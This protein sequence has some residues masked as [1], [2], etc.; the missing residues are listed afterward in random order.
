M[1]MPPDLHPMM[2]SS[3]VLRFTLAVHWAS[4]AGDNAAAVSGAL[5]EPWEALVRREP[6]AVAS[7]CVMKHYHTCANFPIACG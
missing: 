3:E 7:C 4:L 5:W 1:T 2:V 6:G